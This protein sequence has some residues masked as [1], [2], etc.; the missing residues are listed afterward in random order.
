MQIITHRHY[1][2]MRFLFFKKIFI[3]SVLLWV[4]PGGIVSLLGQTVSPATGGANISADDFSTNTYRSLTGP[5]I[6]ETNPGQLTS[7]K[8]RLNAP[9][10][11]RWDTGGTAPS[12][13]VT[14]PKSQQITVTFESRSASEI[15]YDVQGSSG[16]TP[17]NNPHAIEFTGLRIGPAQ[18][19]PLASGQIRNVGSSAPGGQTNYGNVSMVVGA[20]NRVRVE[21]APNASGSVVS[22][23][24]LEAGFSITVYSNVRD[25]FNNFKR[26]EAATWS[27]QN[28]SGGVTSGNLVTAGDNKSAV[29]TGELVG[30]ATI[31]AA[32]GGLN[33]VQS[34]LITVVHTDGDFLDITTQ[35][36]STATAG[37]A[38][39]TQPVVT[40]RD[41]FGNT[42]TGNSFTQITAA[43]NSG[44]GTLQGTTTVTA[45]SGVATFTNLSHQVANDINIRFTGSLLTQATSQ[46]ITVN[47]ASADGLIFTEQ[48]SSASKN[49]TIS[50]PI[51]VQLTDAFGNFV[52]Q[53]GVTVNLEITSGDPGGFSNNSTTSVS[54][55]SSGVAVF[56]DVDFSTSDTYTLKATSSGLNDSPNSEQFTI[57]DAGKLAGFKVE[58]SGGGSIGTQTAGNLFQIQIEAVDGGGNR[59]D[60]SGPRDNFNGSVNLTTAGTFSDGTDSTE[61]SLT[62]GFANPH[63]ITMI[64]SG[65]LRITATNA[66]PDSS[67]SG[68]SNQ[69]TVK[70]AA[71][72]VDYSTISVAPDVMIANGTSEAEVTVQLIDEFGNLHQSNVS[73]S[74]NIFKVGNAGGSFSSTTG[75]GD[76]TYTATLTASNNV[77]VEEIGASI[78]GS[79]ITT[80]NPEVTYTYGSLNKFVVEASGGGNIGTQTA[81]SSFNLRI[82]AQDAHNNTVES[83]D[84]SGNT[85]EI[86]SDQTISSGGGTSP[87][88]NNGILSS[89]SITITSAGSATITARKTA[90]SESGTS[91]TF[92]VQPGAASPTTSTLTPVRNYL[93]ND[94]ADNTPITVQLIDAYG[95][96][97]TGGG[98]NVNLSTTAGSL[99]SVSD[100]GD[101]TYSAT[102]TAGTASATATVT[103]SVNSQSIDD[104]A[105]IT[106]SEFNRWTA[107]AGGNPGNASDWTHTGNWGLGTLPTTGEIVLIPTE[108]Q[109]GT[110]IERFPILDDTN[111]NTVNPVV[112]FLVLET[113][114]N[115]TM[116]DRTLT[117]NNEISGG[118]SLFADNSTINLEGNVDLANFIAGSSGINFNGSSLQTVEGD[119]TGNNLNINNDVEVHGYFEAFSNVNIATGNTL[120]MLSGSQLVSLGDLNLQDG[121]LVGNESQ[122]RI[123]GDING[124]NISLTSTDV[125]FNG[126]A[127]QDINGIQ[128][129]KTFTINNPTTV[130][131]NNNLVISDTLK[132]T[133][134]Q[135][136]ISSG[137]NLATNVTT[138]EVSN[139]RMLRDVEAPQGYRLLSTPLD[140][141]FGNF[142]DG[143]ITQGFTGATLGEE[144][145]PNVL[146]YKEDH[147]GTDQ[148]RWRAPANASDAM[149][150]G[151]G[152]FVYFF[153]D[154]PEDE[155]YNTPFPY[156]LDVEG[157]EN[158]GNGTE[159]T[160][161]VTYTASAD[162]GWNIVGNPYTATVDWDDG[163]WQKT[164]MSNSIYIWDEN[165]NQYLTWNGATG[166]LGDGLIAPF[167]G[168]WVKANGNGTPS[169]KVRKNSKTTGGAF[170]KTADRD[171]E[172]DDEKVPTIGL[173]IFSD[174]R[175]RSTHLS[176]TEA[177]TNGID[178]MDAYRLLPFETDTYLE[179]F[180]LMNDGIE[181]AINNLPR[182]FAKPVEIRI[183]AASVVDGR[184]SPSDVTLT[185]PEM[186]NIPDEWEIILT[187]THNGSEINLK[188]NTFYDFT[189]V[190]QPD[191]STFQKNTTSNFR[192][193]AQDP[194]LTTNPRFVLS[195][196]PGDDAIDLPDEVVLFDNYPNPFNST[197]TIRYGL[198]VEAVIRLDI[199]DILGRRIQTLVNGRKSAG[200]YDI[201]W[202]ARSLASG[203]YFYRLVTPDRVLDKKMIHVK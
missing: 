50:P 202:D 113:S 183:H 78:D 38:F 4:L 120:T 22:A 5:T 175:S 198:P 60:G 73:E 52:S 190:D 137:F 143:T 187:D 142:L 64:E 153:G 118:G 171:K 115:I 59:M 167:Q 90:S 169:L 180:S 111:S 197:T 48:P 164:N 8:I 51:E 106:I 17:P 57:A 28:I 41:P 192:L 147:P 184:Y 135:L 104:D 195:I 26:N 179:I 134:G 92:T 151:R 131:V 42:V 102:L 150:I 114:A 194:E 154:I 27:L 124:T 80:G 178:D 3:L 146:W 86:T 53:S 97:L 121:T 15:V 159:I 133:Q 161:P 29:F 144:L 136:T 170:Y 19:S 93:Q 188:E 39:S 35:P 201:N 172:K 30:S 101:G 75:N 13:T 49:S 105:V 54:T 77:G 56:D 88:F 96:L 157:A 94:G 177:G 148:L 79:N 37:T 44:S 174:G 25:Q 10:G 46:T 203:L 36:S 7:G 34:G 63:D 87:A 189:F 126:S 128:N 112:D 107:N 152:Y 61:I 62:N 108:R 91:N 95:N 182:R 55:N 129:I 47:P 193:L 166:S 58:I 119:F 84:G 149:T 145:Q 81:G 82:T 12:V 65:D 163:T 89:H 139:I 181:L 141:T 155:R 76:G 191:D 173:E 117:V 85:V 2:S 138:G 14:Q 199:Y 32:T 103:G 156:T 11:F 165:T 69:F 24:N 67:E 18:G 45:N 71:P 99:S 130:T 23:Q 40:I 132:I 140:A 1:E 70:P 16:G 100:N 196:E 185:W 66:H 125:E 122:F 72:H 98:D 74:I 127:P 168:F 158:I 6:Q 21:T 20:D 9:S 123:G 116:A 43:R 68:S 162:T 33:T 160:L 200:Y 110:T 176:F 83:F 109:D 31:R 186:N